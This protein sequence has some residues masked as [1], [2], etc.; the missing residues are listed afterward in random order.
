MSHPLVLVAFVLAIFPLSVAAEDAYLREARLAGAALQMQ[1]AAGAA[2]ALAL[3]VSE[4]SPVEAMPGSPRD[5]AWVVWTITTLATKDRESAPAVRFVLV[6]RAGAGLLIWRSTIDTSGVWFEPD[7]LLVED[8]FAVFS[9]RGPSLEE[10]I[11]AARDQAV[12]WVGRLFGRSPDAGEDASGEL[13]QKGLGNG[14]VSA[15]RH[16]RHLDLEVAGGSPFAIEKLALEYPLYWIHVDL[17]PEQGPVSVTWRAPAGLAPG[18]RD[19]HEAKVAP[20]VTSKMA[21]AEAK[22]A[23]V[24]RRL[25]EA[26]KAKPAADQAERMAWVEKAGP[27]LLDAYQKTGQYLPGMTRHEQAQ[28]RFARY[29]GVLE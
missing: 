18:K 6:P 20:D 27:E 1:L 12:A 4:I 13:S 19:P 25:V 3:E 8:E 5:G 22:V 24:G 16:G 2:P 28:K 11:V 23:E 10:D 9:R 14:V 17:T 26:W 15:T 21:E 7:L 29:L